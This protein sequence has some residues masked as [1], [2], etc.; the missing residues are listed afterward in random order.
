MYW[1]IIQAHKASGNLELIS[2]ADSGT[3]VYEVLDLTFFFSREKGFTPSVKV[4]K[5]KYHRL[6]PEG[7]LGQSACCIYEQE[8]SPIWF[9][10]LEFCFALFSITLISN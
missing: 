10:E 6:S 5:S 8:T 9:T 7:H 4:Q 1:F 2:I 3:S